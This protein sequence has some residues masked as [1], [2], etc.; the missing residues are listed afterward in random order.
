MNVAP[1]HLVILALCGAAGT[2][3]RY[4]L[5]IS[6]NRLTAPTIYW[7]IPVVNVLG[8][9]LYGFVVEAMAQ[10]SGWPPQVRLFMLTGFAG[11]FTTFSTLTYQTFELARGGQLAVAALYFVGQAVV[12][13]FALLVGIAIA[14]QLFA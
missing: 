4:G 13:M 11:A 1:L 14:R 2:L 9:L 12:G 10:H 8:C 3:A 5:E 6:I 7:A